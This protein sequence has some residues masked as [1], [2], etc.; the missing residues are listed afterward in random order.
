MAHDGNGVFSPIS[1]SWN[2]ATAG[3]AIDE[4]DWADTLADIVAGLTKAICKDGQSTCS[5]LIPFAA[6]IRTSNTGL[7]AYDTNASHTLA[8]VPGSDLTANRTLSFVTGDANR[9]ITLAGDLA[10]AAASDL[11]TGTDAAKFVTAD[12]FAG[13]NAGK[14]TVQIAVTDPN[15][16]V[17]TT[18]DGKAYFI[19]PPELN[20]MNLVDAD[21]AVTTVSS[22]GLPTVQIHNLTD[23][24]D[25]LST[26]ITV[27]ANEKTSYT[28]AT[29]PVIDTAADDVATGDIIRVDVDVAGT[30]TKG[31]IIILSFQLP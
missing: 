7:T 4:G 23:T 21:A 3:T 25:M 17:L 16:D 9:T 28:A 12:A 14:R 8:F 22:S 1:N 20:G 5:A 31:L 27:D 2:P 15:G 26:R 29:A 24:V 10:A 6:G 19:I 30:S 11:N 13:S 18:G